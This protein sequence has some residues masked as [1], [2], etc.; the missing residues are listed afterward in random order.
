MNGLGVVKFRKKKGVNTSESSF[1]EKVARMNQ[2]VVSFREGRTI[3]PNLYGKDGADQTISIVTD[4]L[5]KWFALLDGT[6]YDDAYAAPAVVRSQTLTLSAREVMCVD[7]HVVRLTFTADDGKEL[8]PWSPGMHLDFYLPSGRKRQYSLCGGSTAADTGQRTSYQ[9]AVRLIPDGGGGSK[10]MHALEVGTRVDVRGP[11]NGFPFVPDGRAVFVAGGIGITA[12]LPMVRAAAETE[13]DWHLVYC[14]RS[15]ASMPFLDEIEAMDASRV[16]VRTDDVDGIASAATL[17][18]QVRGGAV[19]CCGPP[20][21]IESVKIGIDDVP[22]THLYY[23]RFSPPPVRDGVEFEVQLV[24][25][26]TI[27][28]VPSDKSALQVI[29]EARPS[30]AYSCQQGFCGTCRTRVLNGTP[31]HRESRLTSEEQESE[32]L[33]CV[34][35]SAGGRIV[36]DM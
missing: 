1:R 32:M 3:P 13:M 6:A 17:L 26:G 27:L 33:I 5:D 8:P 35:R 28:T 24:D 11:R 9:I 25:D 18:E 21:M 7:E 4:A 19:Y 10:E 16:T 30:V 14:G 15:R 23:E 12:I 22:A 20:P 29:R 31:D 36:L 34:S 2:L